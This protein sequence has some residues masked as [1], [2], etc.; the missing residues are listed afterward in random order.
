[1]SRRRLGDRH[2]EEEGQCGRHCTHK[3]DGTSDEMVTQVP[4]GSW[5][6]DRRRDSCLVEVPSGERHKG[7]AA[8]LL[9]VNGADGPTIERLREV[10]P[11]DDDMLAVGRDG[12]QPP[13]DGY[14]GPSTPL[15][16]QP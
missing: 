13:H 8:Y 4:A 12:R 10:D 2:K 14:Q 3:V 11:G 16:H 7:N 1:M 6:G 15:Q 9:M 5:Y